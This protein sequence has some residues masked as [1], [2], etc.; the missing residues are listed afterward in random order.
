[1]QK[2]GLGE[3]KVR[4]VPGLPASLPEICHTVWKA[5]EESWTVH[6][7][8]REFVKTGFTNSPGNL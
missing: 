7:S 6:E 8:E 3:R 5:Y 4:A 2:A 1:M